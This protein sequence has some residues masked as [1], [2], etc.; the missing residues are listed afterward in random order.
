VLDN[1]GNPEE[2]NIEEPK[3]DINRAPHADANGPYEGIKDHPV[4]FD[5]SKS[6]DPD[7]DTLKY[8]NKIWE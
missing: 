1:D 5:G 7:G 4:Q 3:E 6:Y 2:I 8:V